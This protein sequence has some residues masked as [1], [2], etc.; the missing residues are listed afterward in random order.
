MRR[1]SAPTDRVAIIGAG[2]SPLVGTLA[3]AGYRD[4]LAVDISD[5]ALDRLRLAL[6]DHAAAVTFLPADARSISFERSVGVWHDRA[7]L[8]FLTADADRAAYARRASAA[9]RRGGHLILAEFAPDGPPQCS[10]LPVHRDDPASLAALFTDFTLVE[11]FERT[12][13]TPWAAEQRFSHSVL[14]R[15]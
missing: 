10:G 2:E 3:A 4:V 13:H 12:H 1:V 5:T 14:Q 8:H 7:T 15:R 11:S 9:V 6:G